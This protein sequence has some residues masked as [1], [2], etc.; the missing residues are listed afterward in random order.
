MPEICPPPFHSPRSCRESTFQNFTDDV[1][2]AVTSVLPFGVKPTPWIAILSAWI[3][4]RSFRERTTLSPDLPP[5][6]GLPAGS[7][8]RPHPAAAHASPAEQARATNKRQ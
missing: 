3:T 5:S 1:S 7:G 2:T 4:P 8:V 6:L